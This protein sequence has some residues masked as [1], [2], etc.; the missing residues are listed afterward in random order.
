M[1][2]DAVLGLTMAAMAAMAAPGIAAP[3]RQ[4]RTEFEHLGLTTGHWRLLRPEF[5]IIDLQNA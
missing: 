5:H 1:R 2:S 4:K 3:L